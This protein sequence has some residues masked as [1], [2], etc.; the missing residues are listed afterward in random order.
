[1]INQVKPLLDLIARYESESAAV[2]QGI[3]SDYDVVVWQAF[4][5][6]PPLKPLTSM[7]V[8]EVLEWQTEAI[9]QY[10]QRYN[11]KI[12]YSAAG[13]Y[14]IVYSTLKSLVDSYWKMHDVFDANTQDLLA[15]Q[16][17]RRRGLDRWL[18]ERISDD[19]FADALSMEWASLP[20]SNGQSFYDKDAHGNK[21]LVTRQE[22]MSAL[23]SIKRRRV[24]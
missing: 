8:C 1:M 9:K 23:N 11:S 7:L 14:Q 22:V 4:K 21:A 13:R 17:I 24:S 2:A 5:V 3:E 19:A 6:Y 10:K 20:Y 12:G 15:L 16:L 18:A